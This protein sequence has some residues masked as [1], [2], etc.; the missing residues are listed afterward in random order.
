MPATAQVAAGVAGSV[1]QRPGLI[2]PTAGPPG[3]GAG[4]GDGRVLLR[5]GRHPV[6]LLHDL[7]RLGQAVRDRPGEVVHRE[8]VGDRAILG[9]VA[10]GAK[11][12]LEFADRIGPPVGR[13]QHVEEAAA[14]QPQRGRLL[15]RPRRPA[16]RGAGIAVP[17]LLEDRQRLGGLRDRRRSPI[18]R[19]RIGGGDQR[20]KKPGRGTATGG[21]TGGDARPHLRPERIAGPP[22]LDEQ[23]RGGRRQGRR[24]FQADDPGE[25]LDA[26]VVLEP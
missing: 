19:G 15:R 26:G 20:A 8:R 16:G 1:R 18:D 12:V 2:G 13:D 22:F 11:Q 24:A 3:D 7:D 6:R 4:V 21:D 25:G 14:Q 9:P 17:V 10:V 23:R 5:V